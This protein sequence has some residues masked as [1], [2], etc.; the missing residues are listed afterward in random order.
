VPRREVLKKKILDEAHTLRYSIHPGSTKMYHDL[1]QQFWWTR[2]KRE[3]ACYVSECDTCRKVKADYMK[4]RGLLQPLSVL[5]W[6]WDDI[7]MDFIVGLPLTAC[8]FDSI[9]VIVD[10]LSKSAHFIPVHTHYDARKYA[11]IYIARVLCL[12][13]VPMTIIFDR[14]SQFVTRFWEQLHASL[15]TH[16]IHSSA[17]HLQTDGQTE[18]VNQILEYMLIAYV[19]EHQESWDQ[20]LPWAE[21]SYNNSYQ[22]SLK[23]APFEVLYGHR[24]RTPLNWIEPGE[25]VIFGPDLVEEAEATIHRIQDNLKAVKSRQETYANKRHRP[26]E[27]EVGNHVYLRVSPMKGVKRFG[28]KVKLT[29]RY[30][31]PFPILE[32]CGT[33]A[34]KLDLPPSLAGVHDIFHVSQLKKCLK[35]P[36]DIVLP[37]VTSL[38][39]DLPYLEHPIKV[40]DQMDRVTRCKTIKFFKI[41]WSNHSEGEAT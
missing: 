9:W 20:N 32:K 17:Y 18:R 1:R 3:A 14:G 19:L 12:H 28:V 38:E 39:A 35:A 22:G 27:F 25:K 40:F 34:Y 11:E 2:M 24:C 37:E 5:E 13:G 4:P 6:K 31:G 26:L 8:K 29:S 21:F 15:G 23:M 10:R 33:V 41:Q 7:S 30:I 16:L 36:V